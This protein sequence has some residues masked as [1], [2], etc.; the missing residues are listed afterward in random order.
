MLQGLD[1]EWNEVGSDQRFAT[2]TTLPAGT[3]TFRVEGATS[4]GPWDEPGAA[5]RIEVLPAWWNSWWFRV[6]YI[7]V[8]LLVAAAIYIYR[9]S[10]QKLEEERSERL[11]QAQADLAHINRVSTMG[12]L[13][14]SL[15]HEIKQPIAAA[16]TNANT[17]FRRLSPDPP[18]VPAAPDSTASIV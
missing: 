13:T 6:T 15:A 8:L 16:A 7:A 11:R 2:Y 4:R 9:R 1:R 3:A 5:L 12:D 14:A 18:R 17:S 10:Q